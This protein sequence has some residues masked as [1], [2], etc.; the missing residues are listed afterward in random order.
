MTQLALGILVFAAAVTINYSGARLDEALRAQPCRRLAAANW[1]VAQ[2]CGALVG[3]VIAVRVSMW[4]LP[5]EGL[6]LWLGMF[7]GAGKSAPPS[8]VV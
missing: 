5:L 2:W 7:L 1:S 6:G 8:E 3:F 4:V